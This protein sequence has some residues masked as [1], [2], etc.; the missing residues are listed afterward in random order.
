MKPVKT[1]GSS[2]R[3]THVEIN[4]TI[5]R[6]AYTRPVGLIQGAASFYATRKS[7]C[8]RC[9]LTLTRRREQYVSKFIHLATN[10]RL[11]IIRT[12]IGK[13]FDLNRFNYKEFI[14]IE[15]N[16]FLQLFKCTIFVTQIHN[17]QICTQT[18]C[19]K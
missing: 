12:G 13:H 11:R 14:F 15:N 3:Q 5:I 16:M 19:F 4:K 10:V 8:T 9:F 2:L 1:A 6:C 7:L 17:N 18:K